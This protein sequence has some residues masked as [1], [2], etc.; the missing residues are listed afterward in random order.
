MKANAADPHKT[1]HMKDLMGLKLFLIIDFVFMDVFKTSLFFQP[2][3]A[4]RFIEFFPLR[5][6]SAYSMENSVLKNEG[7]TGLT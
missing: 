6:F 3:F 4:S 5:S 1:F 2:D 7:Q